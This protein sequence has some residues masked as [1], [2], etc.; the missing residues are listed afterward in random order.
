MYDRSAKD[1]C[2]GVD[3][4]LCVILLTNQKP[5]KDLS[6]QFEELSHKYERKIDRG[7]Q[8]KFMWLN[9]AKEKAWGDLFGFNGENKVVILNPGKRKRYTTHEGAIHKDT[10]S[11]TLDAIFGGD[12][13]FN[14]IS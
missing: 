13:R 8:F 6:H 11:Q 10:I 7:A 9:A 2:L 1:I 4:M 3:D 5:S 12:A 14:R